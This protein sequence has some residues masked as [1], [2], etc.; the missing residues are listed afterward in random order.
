MRIQ[1]GENEAKGGKLNKT[2]T[3]APRDTLTNPIP[4]VPNKT[5]SQQKSLYSIHG[6]RLQSHTQEGTYTRALKTAYTDH[7][8]KIEHP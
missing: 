3:W 2:P 4:V 5:H 7:R 6:V 1:I 8:D